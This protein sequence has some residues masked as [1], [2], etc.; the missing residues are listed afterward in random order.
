MHRGEGQHAKGEPRRNDPDNAQPP[1][2]PKENREVGE[3]TDEETQP[4]EEGLAAGAFQQHPTLSPRR[5]E[6]PRAGLMVMGTGSD[7]GDEIKKPTHTRQQPSDTARGQ[8]SEV[9]V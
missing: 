5:H 6:D 7:P 1:R 4:D 3:P 9:S 8:E 2:G